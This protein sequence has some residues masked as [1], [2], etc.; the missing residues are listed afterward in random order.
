MRIL[1]E[2]SG[3]NHSESGKIHCGVYF[4]NKRGHRGI[5]I[6]VLLQ[7]SGLGPVV[8]CQQYV[9]QRED[10][11]TFLFCGVFV[12][13]STFNFHTLEVRLSPRS[14]R[15]GPAACATLEP[16][17]SYSTLR[18]SQSRDSARVALTRFS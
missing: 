6:G 17:A 7:N 3:K 8:L 9:L 13:V 14:A 1:L 11:G 2:Q 12:D 4:A 15:K 16:P 10:S 5:N 18:A